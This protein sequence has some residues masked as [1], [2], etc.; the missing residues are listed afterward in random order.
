[1]NSDSAWSDSTGFVRYRD[2]LAGAPLAD[3]KPIPNRALQNGTF[4]GL[5]V[6]ADIAIATV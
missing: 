2:L 6:H 4:G 5:T 3:R 1:M